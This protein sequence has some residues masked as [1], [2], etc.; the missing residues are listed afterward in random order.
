MR[1]NRLLYFIAFVTIVLV[2]VQFNKLYNA[3]IVEYEL[4]N[5]H[6]IV[7]AGFQNLSRQIDNAAILNTGIIKAAN[8]TAAGKLFY[9]DSLIISRQLSLLQSIFL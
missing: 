5:R 2:L 6:N 1:K 7:Y 3:V 9:K 8:S 4:S